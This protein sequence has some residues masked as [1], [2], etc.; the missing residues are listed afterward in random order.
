MANE[1][2]KLSAWNLRNFPDELKAEL[3]SRAKREKK[4]EPRWVAEKL[5]EALGLPVQSYVDS[6][7]EGGEEEIR[8]GVEQDAEG[9]TAKARPKK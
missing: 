4:T 9:S 7:Y 6:A 5:C 1:R 2:P 3:Q 8:S